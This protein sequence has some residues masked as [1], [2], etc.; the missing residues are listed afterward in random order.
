MVSGIKDDIMNYV[1][2][3]QSQVERVKT[4]S[5]D[6]LLLLDH[7]ISITT[8]ITHE[9]MI[10]IPL[11]GFKRTNDVEMDLHM[12]NGTIFTTVEMSEG[13]ANFLKARWLDCV[14]SESR[15]LE[16]ETDDGNEEE[17]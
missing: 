12:T 2:S 17:T 7:V 5:G 3:E 14:A 8:T 15:I 13:K 9:P 6:T 11:P 1:K 16:G 4:K 10:Q